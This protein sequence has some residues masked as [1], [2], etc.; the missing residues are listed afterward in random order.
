MA[1]AEELGTAS[2]VEEAKSPDQGQ[3]LPPREDSVLGHFP[4]LG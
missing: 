2:K 3:R 1:G 4:V